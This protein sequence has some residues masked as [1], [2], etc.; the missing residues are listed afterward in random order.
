M[1][2][3]AADVPEYKGRYLSFAGATFSP[4]PV[5]RPHPPIWVG[6]APGIVSAP[7]V[8]RCAELGDAWHPLGLGLD[9]IEKGLVT[10]R[11][12]AGRFGRGAGPG[13]AP[14]NL[15]D[16]TEPAKG[17]RA[18]S[19]PGVRGRDRVRCPPGAGTRRRWV[20]FRPAPSRRAGNDAEH[21]ASRARGQACGGLIGHR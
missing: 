1:A 9:E 4:R 12:L 15:L 16:F 6:G 7:A 18:G 10:L 19:V 5:Q 2:A 8:R 3:W 14:R 17:K 20:T 11:H 21:G 13:L